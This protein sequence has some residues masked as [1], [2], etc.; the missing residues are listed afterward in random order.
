LETNT[1]GSTGTYILA[2]LLV[3]LSKI[4]CGGTR[5]QTEQFLL[6]VGASLTS[7]RTVESD[8]SINPIKYQHGAAPWHN[9]FERHYFCKSQRH[10]GRAIILASPAFLSNRVDEK[11]C[12]ILR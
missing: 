9:A 11:V 4:I 12:T 10:R 5:H 3:E 7:T 8:G 2:L 6:W 1:S